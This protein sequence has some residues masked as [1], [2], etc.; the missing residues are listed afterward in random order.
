MHTTGKRD[1][2]GNSWFEVKLREGR[3]QQIRKMFK[4]MGHPVSKLKRVAIGPISDP[5]LTAGV[6]RELT[7]QEVKMLATM[8]D[9]KPPKQRR[10][11][12]PRGAAATTRRT[13]AKKPPRPRASPAAGSKKKSAAGGRAP[14]RGA[15]SS[16]KTNKRGRR[17]SSP[18]A[19]AERK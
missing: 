8:Q 9:A 18:A 2:E 12:T 16:T 10:T 11:T 17:A 5:K 7:K 6:W 19:A 13:T 14:A 15:S 1:D 4:A 3:T